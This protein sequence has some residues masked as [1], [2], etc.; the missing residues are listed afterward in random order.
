MENETAMD[1]NETAQQQQVHDQQ[2][3]AAKIEEV[4]TA[5]G[6]ALLQLQKEQEGV[7]ETMTLMTTERAQ[8]VELVQ[9]LGTRVANISDIQEETGAAVLA[10]GKLLAAMDTRF[11]LLTSVAAQHQDL[12]VKHG[13]ETPLPK[14]DPLAN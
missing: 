4:F 3:A 2:A 14:Y 5:F 7:R 6:N 9:C 11:Q 10:F 1:H 12:F 8:V 13:W